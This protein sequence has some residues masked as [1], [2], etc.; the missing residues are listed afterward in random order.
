[1][2]FNGSST[3]ELVASILNDV[4]QPISANYSPGVLWLNCLI[5][6]L[7][8]TSC[9]YLVYI[10]FTS[11]LYLVYILFI[12]CL[13]LVFNVYIC[14]LFVYFLYCFI[15]YLYVIYS[16]FVF[17]CM[18]CIPCSLHFCFLTVP[19]PSSHPS[20]LPPSPP[21]PPSLPPLP[22]LPLSPLY[23]IDIYLFLTPK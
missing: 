1:M 12:S 18:V 16:L 8:F 14:I 15:Y 7:L 23:R 21:H 10:L 9:L 5:L 2:P 3:A 11:C 6:Y 13:Y 17:L 22:F 4:P 19:L 20:S